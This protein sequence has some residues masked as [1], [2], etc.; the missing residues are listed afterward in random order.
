MKFTTKFT[1]K[2]DSQEFGYDG[3]ALPEEHLTMEFPAED[4]NAIQ[5]FSAFKKF[6]LASGFSETTISSGA[7]SL[8]FHESLSLDEMRKTAKEYDLILEEDYS[9][10]IGELEDKIEELEGKIISLKAHLSRAENPDNPNYTD[11][12]LEA[13]ET[14]AKKKEITKQTL[15]NAYQ[16]CNDCG[17]QYGTYVAGVS[18]HWIGKCDV[19]GQIK[20]TTEARDFDYLKKGIEE[21]SK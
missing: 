7:V 21:L 2:Y 10:K 11:S 14:Q 16:V 9:K 15:K 5:I 1:F 18:S 3:E 13:M 20:A 8:A 19:C 4:L 12:E 6:L 17:E